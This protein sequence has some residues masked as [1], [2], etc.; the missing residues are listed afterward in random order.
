MYL[1]GLSLNA[2]NPEMRRQIGY[3]SDRPL[4]YPH[5]TVEENLFFFGGLYDVAPLRERVDSLLQAVGL[6]DRRHSMAGTLSR[7]LQQRL[8]LARSMIHQPSIMLLDEPF[9]ALDPEAT[10]MLE[11]LLQRLRPKSQTVIMTIHNLEQ[12][13]ELCDHLVILARGAVAYQA[14]RTSLT[15]SGLRE[16]YWQYTQGAS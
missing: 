15:L 14:D 10:R 3:L 12:G 7:G 9:T 16:T 11:G 4:I 2:D 5:L 6:V 1:N 8:S 13:L